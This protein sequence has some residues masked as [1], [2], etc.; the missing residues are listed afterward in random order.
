M[1]SSWFSDN[2]NQGNFH[3]YPKRYISQV[4]RLRQ[5]L[6]IFYWII[7]NAYYSVNEIMWHIGYR[8]CFFYACIALCGCAVIGK[9]S[10]PSKLTVQDS[11][12]DKMNKIE[13]RASEKS[14]WNRVPWAP[15]KH[16]GKL[17]AVSSSTAKNSSKEITLADRRNGDSES[18]NSVR[19]VVWETHLQQ[20]YS[21]PVGASHK[22]VLVSRLPA[23]TA[24]R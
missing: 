5:K 21:L 17:K 1:P 22:P 4:K 11:R 9:N 8:A 7:K 12:T 10:L 2:Q 18:I 24:T 13:F 3:R 15:Q 19:Q 23:T 14:V 6:N 20:L 16:R